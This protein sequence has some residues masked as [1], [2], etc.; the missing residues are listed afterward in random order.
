MKRFAHFPFWGLCLFALLLS[1]GRERQHFRFAGFQE[2]ARDTVFIEFSDTVYPASSFKLDRLFRCDGYYFL[3]IRELLRAPFG[4]SREIIMALSE[5][6]MS[7]RSV[8]RPPAGR[9]ALKDGHLVAID[10]YYG[11]LFDFNT[12]SWSWENYR[13]DP[14]AVAV[15][16][17]DEDWVLR[18]S[19]QGE[20]GY[21]SW[22]I[23]KHDSTEYAFG[24]L[25]GQV[26]RIDSTYYE[27][28]ST[29]IYKIPQP[30]IGFPCDSAMRYESAK[31]ATL[32]S[33][34]FYRNG[35]FTPHTPILPLIE[36]DHA[37]TTG[38]SREL[39]PLYDLSP[40]Y[41]KEFMHYNKPD[42]VI[43]GSL[44]SA[45][46][47]YCLLNT[48]A[49]TVLTKLDEDH[50]STIHEFSKR[51]EVQGCH[52]WT[53][54]E[55]S[56][57]EILVILAS[58]GADASSLIEVG[59]NGNR[60]VSIQYPQGL[61]PRENDGFEPL[62][63]WFLLH[64]GSFKFEDA[65]VEEEALGGK[66]SCLGLVPDHFTR[67]EELRSTEPK[68]TN[69]IAKQ[70]TD[71]LFVYSEY[72]VRERDSIVAAVCLVWQTKDLFYPEFYRSVYNELSE[73]I[74]RRFGPEDAIRHTS[75]SEYK[76]WLSAP[77]SIILECSERD[78][79]VNFF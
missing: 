31:D 58:D 60:I 18:S 33:A 68:R 54:P 69:V 26:H 9:I 27:V 77:F 48:T 50:L 37:Y 38:S 57:E 45:D 47:L 55:K 34:L 40:L 3:S 36:F 15:L 21:M 13:I 61:V 49:N 11:S 65:V 76:E 64:W 29:R 46:T 44:K 1:C 75:F 66:I 74:C 39:T 70:I 79:T 59:K 8:P 24:S 23:N 51:Y 42:T 73:A 43:L 28:S 19:D 32:I 5:K 14:D 20:F 4:G 30:N 62:L 12:E 53:D 22:F 71:S 7:P 25:Y 78:V 10:R 16:Y 63:N 67:T 2:E 41:D 17:E 6:T 56:D 72:R 35:Y 52:I